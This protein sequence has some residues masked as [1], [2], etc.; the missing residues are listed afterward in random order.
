MFNLR[1]EPD[2]Y[3]LTADIP[4]LDENSVKVRVEGNRLHIS[5]DQQSVREVKDPGGRVVQRSS[6]V[7]SFRQNLQLPADARGDLAEPKYEDG[8]L[9]I[10]VPRT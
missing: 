1:E 3:V 5:A 7:S 9:V 6:S 10:S 4:D 8:K 2:R